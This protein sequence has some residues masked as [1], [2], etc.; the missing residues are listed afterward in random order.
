MGGERDIDKL[1]GT[2]VLVF[3]KVA[4]AVVQAFEAQILPSVVK[5]LGRRIEVEN[6]DEGTIAGPRSGQPHGGLVG[7]TR[8]WLP[9]EC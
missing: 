8:A 5:R 7:Q 1:R 9:V 6:G 4:E 2:Q 3:P